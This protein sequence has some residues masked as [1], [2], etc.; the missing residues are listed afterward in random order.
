M[1]QRLFPQHWSC[2]YILDRFRFKCGRAIH[3]G[4]PWLPAGAVAFVEQW[5]SSTDLVVEFGAGRSTP[6]FAE[7]CGRVVSVET[8]E[9]WYSWVLRASASRENVTLLLSDPSSP[10][11]YLQ[12]ATLLDLDAAD[13]ALVDG[14]HRGDSALWL[15]DR[16]RPG[17]L[18]IIDDIHRYL[19]SSCGAPYARTNGD[20]PVTEIWA[21]FADHVRAWRTVRFTNGVTET[22]VFVV[23]CESQRKT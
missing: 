9:G 7:R 2:R 19:P 15:V 10:S 18:L 23:P 8:D 17:G 11:A 20:G 6:W 21:T 4:R 12:K 1:G 22:A 3:P 14:K 13:V 16:L 5:L